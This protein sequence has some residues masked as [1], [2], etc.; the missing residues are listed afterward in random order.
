M[1]DH[2]T[3]GDTVLP[4]WTW[5]KLKVVRMLFITAFFLL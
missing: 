4:G 1:D 5:E 2:E 3:A